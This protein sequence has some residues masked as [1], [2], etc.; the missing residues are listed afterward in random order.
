M[1]EH[2]SRELFGVWLGRVARLWRAGID[3]RLAAFGL[4]ESRWLTLIHLSRMQAPVTQRALAE[5]AGVQEPTLVRTLDWLESQELIERRPIA[6]DR[7]AKSVHLTDKALP[8]LQHIQVVVE[9]LRAEILA[10]VSDA[11]IDTCL[12]TFEYMAEKLGEPLILQPFHD[13]SKDK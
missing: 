12:R 7:R 1:T 4:T 8:S 9:S 10:G 5:T 11:D 3:H 2:K 13:N 6:E